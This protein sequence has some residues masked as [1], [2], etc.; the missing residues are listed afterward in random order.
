MEFGA[1]LTCLGIFSMFGACILLFYTGMQIKGAAEIHSNTMEAIA[2]LKNCTLK[3]HD[4]IQNWILETNIA[5]E[6]SET[7][8]ANVREFCAKRYLDI[9]KRIQEV[10]K[11]FADMNSTTKMLN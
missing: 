2:D 10:E 11:T 9:E 3:E 1:V 8:S 5:I 6:A 7:K 4:Q